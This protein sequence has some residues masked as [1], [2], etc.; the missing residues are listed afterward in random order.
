M[1]LIFVRH[2]LPLRSEGSGGPADP[3]LAPEGW[4]Q[5]HKLAEWLEAEELHGIIV[6]PSRRAQETAIPLAEMLGLDPVVDADLAEF[7]QGAASYVPF[8]ELRELG[9]S[10]WEALSRGQFI[11]T[12]VDPLEFRRRIVTRIEEIILSHPGQRLVISTH[13]GVI[14]AYVG[15]LLAQEPPLWFGPGYASISRVAGARDGKRGVI[16]LN[17]TGH[18]RDLDV[19]KM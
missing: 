19:A 18:V 1:E 15:H 16:S 10:R 14:N 2:A 11:N 5:A 9:D 12:N 8:E 4:K 3:W 7:D 17:E 6:S 13:A